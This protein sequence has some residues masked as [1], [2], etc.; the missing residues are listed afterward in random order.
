MKL[1]LD[2][3]WDFLQ[4]VFGEEVK[5]ELAKKDEREAKDQLMALYQALL[6]IETKTELFVGSLEAIVGAEPASLATEGRAKMQA[7]TTSARDLLASLPILAQA[8][9][10][11]LPALSIHRHEL[12]QE[13]ES[14]RQSRAMVISRLEEEVE[15]IERGG[16]ESQILSD[17]YMK[18]LDNLGK[19]K[20]ASEN[21]RTFIAE[22]FSFRDLV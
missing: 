18:S 2:F 7:A 10:T 19:I 16:Y 6:Q 5:Q 20:A 3:L 8:L 22:Q 15:K 1:S 4:P 13:I 11:L 12:I 17:L 14:Y 9:E 21:L